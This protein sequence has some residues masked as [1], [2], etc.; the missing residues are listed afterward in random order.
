MAG[1]PYD[2]TNLS[3]SFLYQNS[4]RL[5]FCC[6]QPNIGG[7]RSKNKKRNDTIQ[8]RRTRIILI[9]NNANHDKGNHS[10]PLEEIEARALNFSLGSH[11]RRIL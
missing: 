8:N 9:P 4:E 6:L 5:T 11:Q 2:F 1:W 3:A 10:Q 7:D